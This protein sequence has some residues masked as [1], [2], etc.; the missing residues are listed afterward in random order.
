MPRKI[1]KPEEII[2][3]LR[4]VEVLTSQACADDCVVERR[5]SGARKQEKGLLPQLQQ[6]DLRLLK[7]VIG[8][9]RSSHD[10]YNPP[11]LHFTHLLQAGLNQANFQI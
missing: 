4:Q 3:K 6:V 7:A 11:I 10:C 9:L 8:V 2:A 5:A 1:Y